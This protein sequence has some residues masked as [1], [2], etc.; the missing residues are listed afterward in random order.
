M[1]AA[2]LTQHYGLQDVTLQPAERGFVAETYH[3]Q[4]GGQQYFAKHT[5]NGRYSRYLPTALPALRE[6]HENGMTGIS[7]PIPARDGRLMIEVNNRPFFLLNYIDAAWTFDYPQADYIALLARIHQSRTRSQPDQ[8]GFGQPFR[9]SLLAY[10]DHLWKDTLTNPHERALQQQLRNEREWLEIRW[11]R[12]ERL[13]AQLQQRDFP[14]V[15]T[16]GD[17]PGNVLQ[18]ADG[19]LFIVDWDDLLLAPPERDLW[20][21]LDSPDFL[22]AYRQY[23]PS[24]EPDWDLYA[25]YLYWRYFDDLEGFIDQVMLPGRDD[26]FKAHNLTRLRDDLNGWLRPLME[27]HNL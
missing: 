25:Y 22:A 12:F 4:A 1:I 5:R 21:H 15:L 9:A 20:F 13:A 11:L 14:W 26:A 16:H 27:K 3:V 18:A 7:Y 10:L 19:R 17:A 24:Y 23:F 2:A 6:L 8:E